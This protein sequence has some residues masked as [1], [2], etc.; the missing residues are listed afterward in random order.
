MENAAGN[1]DR[2]GSRYERYEEAEPSD[3]LET[4]DTDLEVGKE[5]SVGSREQQKVRGQSGDVP[6]EKLEQENV[7]IVDW[8]GPYDPEN[9]SV[10]LYT[11]IRT[12]D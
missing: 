1:L 6:R 11:A 5:D 3:T 8:N 10:Y 7:E 12:Q 4:L 2:P 9:P